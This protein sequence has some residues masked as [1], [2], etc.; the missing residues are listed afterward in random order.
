MNKLFST[1]LLVA[2]TLGIRITE[3]STGDALHCDWKEA[4]KTFY[5][6]FD[7]N[8]DGYLTP[9]EAADGVETTSGRKFTESEKQAEIEA[10][11]ESM[12]LDRPNNVEVK[13]NADQE[14]EAGEKFKL[15]DNQKYWCGKAAFIKEKLAD[16]P[17]PNTTAAEISAEGPLHFH[18]SKKGSSSSSSSG[19]SWPSSSNKCHRC[20]VRANYRP[21]GGKWHPKTKHTRKIESSPS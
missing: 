14:I 8:G 13:T 18:G 12:K 7:T 4:V 9:K 6:Q 10:W 16:K 2:C 5:K 19:N 17:T 11:T 21:S 20:T 15:E 3:P 1:A